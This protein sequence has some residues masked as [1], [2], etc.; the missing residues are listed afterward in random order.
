MPCEICKFVL[1]FA[2]LLCSCLIGAAVNLALVTPEKAIKL[3]AND[4]FRH[5]LAKDG[6]VL[7]LRK[8]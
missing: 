2:N 8:F 6:Y 4:L 7:L 5:H 3:A 1:L